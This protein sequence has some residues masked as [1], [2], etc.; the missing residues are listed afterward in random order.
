MSEPRK[1]HTGGASGSPYSAG[2]SRPAGSGMPD[3]DQYE[4]ARRRAQQLASQN[5]RRRVVQQPVRTAQGRHIHQHPVQEEPVQTPPPAE[6]QTP[7]P[8]QEPEAPRELTRA[9]RQAMAYRAAAE[10]KYGNTASF[11]AQRRT[12]RQPSQG[13]TQ[14]ARP[15]TRRLD[16]DQRRSSR[17]AP[18]APAEAPAS[19]G[20]RMEEETPRRRAPEASA[21]KSTYR[22]GKSGSAGGGRKPPRDGDAPRGKKGGK[23]GAGPYDGKGKKKKK[24]GLWWKI[25]LITLCIILLIFGGAYALIMAAIAPSGGA[26]KISQLINTPKEFQGKELNI[27]VTGV[28]RSSTDDLSAGAANDSNVNDGMTDKIGIASCRERV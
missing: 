22:A 28:D 9:Q 3:Q 20:I 6:A 21:E 5:A 17:P 1:L 12:V 14:A 16:T 25:L 18:A 10:R 26:I 15:Q 23:K 4:A 7:P 24:N 27:L 8:V 11:P 13:G 2:S 19:G